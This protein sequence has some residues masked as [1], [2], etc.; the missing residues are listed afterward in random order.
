M[1][2]R[3]RLDKQTI[4]VENSFMV[5]DIVVPAG[6]LG[7]IYTSPYELDWAEFNIAGLG[8]KITVGQMF[9]DGIKYSILDKECCKE[10]HVN[11]VQMVW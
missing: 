2:G 7:V 3:K 10:V 6:T 9:L 8:I 11:G 1:F 4:V 5:D